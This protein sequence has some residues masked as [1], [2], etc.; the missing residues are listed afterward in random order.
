MIRFE[1]KPEVVEW[2]EQEY[3]G[4]PGPAELIEGI[5]GLMI[6]HKCITAEPDA[7]LL[8]ACKMVLDAISREDDLLVAFRGEDLEQINRAIAR[9]EGG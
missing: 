7:D 6:A 2:L 4:G 3:I 9:A 1:I 5:M 8:A